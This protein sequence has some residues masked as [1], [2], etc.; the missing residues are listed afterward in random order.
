MHPV[1]GPVLAMAAAAYVLALIALWRHG[2][3]SLWNA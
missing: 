1:S 3:K 2:Y